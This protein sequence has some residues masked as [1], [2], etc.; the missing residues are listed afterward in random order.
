[1]RSMPEEFY[2][3]QLIQVIQI[4][5]GV[6]LGSTVAYYFSQSISDRGRRHSMIIDSAVKI[7]V[8]LE[9]LDKIGVEFIRGTCREAHLVNHAFK[10]VSSKLSCA[11]IVIGK[12]NNSAAER[13]IDK[14]IN[15]LRKLRD[16]FTGA[17]FPLKSSYESGQSGIFS[18]EIEDIHFALDRLA[19]VIA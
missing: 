9:S 19:G 12:L 16:K 15:L 17:D 2:S 18:K 6:T 11:K 7:G 14:A 3:F 8:L 4:I 5:S 1:M 13:E 10:R